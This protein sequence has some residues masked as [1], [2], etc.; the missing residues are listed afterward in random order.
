MNNIFIRTGLAPYRIDTYNELHKRLN[1]KMCFYYREGGDQKHDFG[2][3]ESQCDFKPI[4]LD[5]KYMGSDNRK[6]CKGLWRMLRQ[7]K[8]DVVIVPEFQISAIQVLLY[9]WVTR[10]KF[11]I[12]SQLHSYAAH[13]F[14]F[15][16]AFLFTACHRKPLSG[17]HADQTNVH[18]VF[19]YI[20]F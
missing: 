17:V 10:C 11:K 2:L 1:M 18:I 7:D 6:W 12:V 8:P 5:G 3:L 15:R 14:A 4:Y 9:R 20:V 19:S 16:T 13:Q